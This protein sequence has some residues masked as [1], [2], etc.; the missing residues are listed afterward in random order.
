MLHG[1]V[2]PHPDQKK[3]ATCIKLNFA[4]LTACLLFFIACVDEEYISK[5]F[6]PSDDLWIIGININ[7]R[8]R[9]TFLTLIMMV[10]QAV[11]LVSEDIGEPIIAFT[12]YNTQCDDIR[13]FS[14]FELQMKTNLFYLS[15]G[16]LKIIKIFVMVQRLDMLLLVYF[17]EEIGS[18]FTVHNILA[19]KQFLNEPHYIPD[20]TDVRFVARLCKLF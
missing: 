13:F 12:V 1:P 20:S 8:V 5:S 3:L 17:T 2:V 19:P 16:A 10:V 15:K 7:T 6:G 18:I 4:V 9:Y 14:R 11:M